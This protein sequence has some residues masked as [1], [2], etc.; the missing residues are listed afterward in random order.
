MATG[1]EGYLVLHQLGFSMIIS[2]ANASR[3]LAVQCSIESWQGW[4]T[5]AS[6]SLEYFYVSGTPGIPPGFKRHG[7]IFPRWVFRNWRPEAG[8]RVR[9]LHDFPIVRVV[10]LNRMLVSECETNLVVNGLGRIFRTYDNVIGERIDDPPVRIGFFGTGILLIER[11]CNCLQRVLPWALDQLLKRLTR[12]NSWNFVDLLP[13]L[14][15]TDTFCAH[16][17]NLQN[18]YLFRVWHCRGIK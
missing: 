9:Q 4:K 11:T 12:V 18:H 8:R 10:E 14:L 16:T 3:L 1:E 15:L 7:L 2:V 6:W 5:G 13:L 17:K